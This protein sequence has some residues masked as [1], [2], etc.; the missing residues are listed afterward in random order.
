M[1][2]GIIESVGKITRITENG[3]NKTFY[4]ESSISEELGIDQSVS[5]SGVCMTVEGVEGH[6]HRVTAIK[7]TL[8]R[9]TFKH[10]KVGSSVNLERCM[11]IGGRL[12]GHMVQGHVDA[13]LECIQKKT[14]EGSWVYTF[15]FSKSDA[16]L[17]VEKGSVSIDG[18]SLTV[19]AL[20][21]EKFDVAIIP[22]TF[23]NTCFQFLEAGDTINVEFDILGKYIQRILAHQSTA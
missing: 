8:D 1:F 7:E 16:P 12:D 19:A 14:L 21:K 15:A 4:I 20:A 10:L 3:S 13:E 11:Q 2:T 9:S 17:L 22:Y 6:T 5:H 18:V 23:D